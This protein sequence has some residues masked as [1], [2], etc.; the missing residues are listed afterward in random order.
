MKLEG[1]RVDDE[2]YEWRKRRK[3][4]RWSIRRRIMRRL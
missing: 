3:V 2:K 1:G 4:E